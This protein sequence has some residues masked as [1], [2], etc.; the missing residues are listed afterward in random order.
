MKSKFKSKCNFNNILCL[1]KILFLTFVF[2]IG[3]TFFLFFKFSSKISK[4]I[5][6][7][8]EAEIN[9]V[10]YSFITNKIN[11]DL[12][13]KETLKNILII[14]KNK[15][16]EILYVDF[17]WDI[18]YQV[19]DS[20]S[21]TLTDSF[22]DMEQGDIEIAYFDK[23]ISHKTNGIILNIPIGSIFNNNYFYNI[24]PKVPVK[25][26]FVG[27]VLTNLETKITNYGL[28]NALVEVFVFIEFHNQIMAPFATKDI[29]FK[30]DAV[31]ASMMIEGKVPS[32]YNGT[33]NKT[34]DI[35]SESLEN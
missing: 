31:I 22:E 20:I 6:Q 21:N 26:N 12:L 24:G 5:I 17:N 11:H 25:V 35:Y 32:F 29:T 3:F 10:N 27:A 33:I 28:N 23:S 4:N 19:L 13:N 15:N 14:T 7:I 30:Y 34:S 2:I 18:A 8:S 1:S 16:D 9:K